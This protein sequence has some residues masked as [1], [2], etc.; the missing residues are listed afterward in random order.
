MIDIGDTV[1][2]Q[3]IEG[4]YSFL[5]GTG[6]IIQMLPL[7]S[8]KDDRILVLLSD[9]GNNIRNIYVSRMQIKLTGKSLCRSRKED[10]KNRNNRQ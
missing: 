4:F 7:T 1:K 2:L 6:G 3:N 10:A 9:D 8:D 5:N